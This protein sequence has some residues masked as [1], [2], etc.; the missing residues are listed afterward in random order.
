MILTLIF[1]N[2]EEH[3]S[4]G[5]MLSFNSYLSV[6]VIHGMLIALSDLQIISHESQDKYEQHEMPDTTWCLK[7]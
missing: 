5:F 6:C 4:A 2:L 3:D 7:A 1:P